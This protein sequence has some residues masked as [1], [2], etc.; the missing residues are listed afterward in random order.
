MD[1]TSAGTTAQLADWAHAFRL[2]DAPPE[3]VERMKALVLD[4]LRVIAVGA[5]LPWSR[6]VRRGR[7]PRSPA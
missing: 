1:K 7:A 3:V 4:L 5:R 6:A 2:D